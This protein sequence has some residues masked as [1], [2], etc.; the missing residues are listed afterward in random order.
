MLPDGTHFMAAHDE[1]LELVPRD[2]VARAIDFEMKKHGLDCVYL[3]ISHQ[4]AGR[5]QFNAD[6][7]YGDL[8]DDWHFTDRCY[9]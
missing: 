6:T 7:H 4:S 1:R 3:D 8:P 5:S 2:F 9:R